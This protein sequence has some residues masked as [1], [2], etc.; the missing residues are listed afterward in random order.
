M[1]DE[2][3]NKTIAL[4]DVI[5]HPKNY[6]AHPPA[7]IEIL[8][9]S[10][11]E[12][13]QVESIAVQ[14]H[15]A[16]S[17]YTLI[18]GHGVVEAMRAEKLKRVRADIIP[19]S[20]SPKKAIA[21]LAASNE[22]AKHSTPDEVQLAAIVS[23]MAA[24]NETELARLAAGNAAR[25]KELLA[26]NALAL[27]DKR[28][29]VEQDPGEIKL[30]KLKEWQKKWGIEYGQL[31]KID[32]H[33]VLCGDSAKSELIARLFEQFKKPDYLIYDLDWDSKVV[34]PEFEWKGI[35][36]Y[37]DGFRA[38]D[39]IKK[40]G[41]PTWI[42]TWDG[43]T[44][45]YTPNRPLRRSKYAL[46]FGKIDEY[47][48]N[49]AHYGDAGDECNVSNTRGSYRFIPDPRGK[50]LSDVFSLHLPRL[51]SDGYHP[52][53]KPLDW[54]RLL[55]GNCFP[56]NVFD[57]FLGAGGTLLACDQLGKQ[58]IGIEINP[59]YVAYLIEQCSTLGLS[60]VKL[61][62]KWR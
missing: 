16:D 24:A 58:C 46:W 10:L 35:I 40:F 31:W 51:H 62:E 44:S 22:T 23:G 48:F 14:A 45:W 53:E 33:L 61:E 13:S 38:A 15:K 18:A 28:P 49:G 30:E 54:V 26:A 37:C 5:P 47:N 52:Y 56:G 17:K 9:E 32:K 20:W 60:P 2:V 25:L 21:Y 57:P 34:L 36:A 27:E 3:V 59:L 42:F 1:K 11:R 50:H 7:Q 55:I 8:R 39:V 6:N 29:G 43:Y 41:A 12:F 4:S 19:A